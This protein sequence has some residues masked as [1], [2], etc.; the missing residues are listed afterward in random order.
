M[1]ACGESPVVR[2]YFDD[3]K[4]SR[5]VYAALKG[6]KAGVE[7]CLRSGIAIDCRGKYGVTPLIVVIELTNKDAVLLLLEKGADPNLQDDSGQSAMSEAARSEDIW[8]LQTVLKH[9]GDVNLVSKKNEETPL[10]AAVASRRVA[11]VE[12]VLKSGANINA[13]EMHGETALKR[14]GCFNQFDIM[15]YL[16]NAGADYRIENLSHKTV[17]YELQ[18]GGVAPKYVPER[19]AVIDWFKKKGFWRQE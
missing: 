8:F 15:M 2:R 6:D 3:S 11:N 18:N 14:A 17:L 7:D 9:K 10:F 12:L 1:I 16:L 13:Q 5:L 4:E 19:D